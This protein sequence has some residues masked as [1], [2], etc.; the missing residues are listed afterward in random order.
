MTFNMIKDLSI[1][2]TID[3]STL[4]K[5]CNK[6]SLCIA[7]S[8]NEAVISNSNTLDIDLQFGKLY[9]KINDESIKYRF[10]PS[11]EL[12]TLISK[13]LTDDNKLVSSLESSLATKVQNVYKTLL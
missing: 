11:N 8:I 13:A 12:E 9:I 5:L 1:L 2:T 4:I 7:N 10:E 6:V 3:E